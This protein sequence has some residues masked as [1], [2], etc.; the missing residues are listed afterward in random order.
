MWFFSLGEH[1]DEELVKHEGIEDN[2]AR[3]EDK[4]PAIK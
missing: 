1:S 4:G 3:V 2:E